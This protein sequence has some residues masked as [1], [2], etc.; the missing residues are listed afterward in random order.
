MVDLLKRCIKCGSNVA[1]SVE[2]EVEKEG[3][4]KIGHYVNSVWFCD[5]CFKKP[6]DFGKQAQPMFHLILHGLMKQVSCSYP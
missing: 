4:L 2:S 3:Q 5:D 6:E 1:D